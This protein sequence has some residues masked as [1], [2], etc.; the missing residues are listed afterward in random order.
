VPPSD[1]GALNATGAA[2][3]SGGAQRTRRAVAVIARRASVA[4]APQLRNGAFGA[5]GRAAVVPMAARRSLVVTVA[6]E[7][8]K[9][10]Y[11]AE[12]RARLLPPAALPERSVERPS[13]PGLV[14]V[15]N[16]APTRRGADNTRL[17]LRASCSPAILR[18]S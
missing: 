5:L 11:Q 18:R 14:H 2:S 16:D 3:C 15:D 6:A 8:E 17:H 10:E 12:V 4:L 9:F 1:R 13:P 7:E